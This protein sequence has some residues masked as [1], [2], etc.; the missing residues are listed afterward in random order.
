MY[1][2]SRRRYALL[3][4]F[5]KMSI[6]SVAVYPRVIRGKRYKP[7]RVGYIARGLC[8]NTTAWSRFVDN[9]RSKFYTNSVVLLKKRGMLRSK[10]LYTPLSRIIRRK[11]YR[12]LFQN[13]F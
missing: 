2:G 5:V 9:T 6:R 10:Y 11:Q 12:S 8:V 3:G 13:I 1:R 7:L 4:D